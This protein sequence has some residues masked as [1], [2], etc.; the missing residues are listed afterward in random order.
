MKLTTLLFSALAAAAPSV[1]AGATPALFD[2]TSTT[3]GLDGL[4]WSNCMYSLGSVYIGNVKYS[5]GSE[6]LLLS[7]GSSEYGISF[8]SFHAAPTGWQSM[9]VFPNASK[10]IGFTTPHSGS[11]PAG[12]QLVGF[13]SWNGKFKLDTGSGPAEKWMAC[14]VP[15]TEAN[16]SWKI[17]WDG[18]GSLATT[19]GCSRVSLKV[20]KATE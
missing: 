5:T 10:P 7:G 17:H 9:Y 13:G 2:L 8:T 1:L 14:K 11:V 6:P 20:G 3:D 18:K 19:A 16:G 15:E 12:A 4:V